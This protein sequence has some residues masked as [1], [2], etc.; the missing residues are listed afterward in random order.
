MRQAIIWISGGLFY[1]CIYATLSLH[2]LSMGRPIHRLG[3]MQTVYAIKVMEVMTTG[4]HFVH[5]GF[6]TSQ[7][8]MHN[9]IVGQDICKY[10]DNWWLLANM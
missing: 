8:K 6:V 5:D 3:H 9:A 7:P 10:E 2:N 1:W 4:V